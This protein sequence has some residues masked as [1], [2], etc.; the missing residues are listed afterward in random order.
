MWKSAFRWRTANQK[1]Y[2]ETAQATST[3]IDARTI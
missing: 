3:A 2:A 1:Q